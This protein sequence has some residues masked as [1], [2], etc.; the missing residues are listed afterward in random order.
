MLCLP[1]LREYSTIARD[2]SRGESVSTPRGTVTFP[3][4]YGDRELLAR[5]AATPTADAYLF[6]PY[7]PMLPFLTA[8]EHVSKHDVFVPGYTSP[9]EYYE[10]CASAMQRASWVVI[11]RNWTDPAFLRSVFPAL[12]DPRRPE[13]VRFEAALEHGFEFVAR[14][15]AFE[16]RRRSGST[17]ELCGRST[18]WEPER[19]SR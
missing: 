12:A 6:Y 18:Q 2:A 19:T 3:G 9:S 13:T 4:G 17:S 1:A 5:I 15:G 16:L 8:R 14:E 7:M 11:N 10:A